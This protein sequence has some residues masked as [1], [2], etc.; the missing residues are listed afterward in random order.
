MADTVTGEDADQPEKRGR[1]FRISAKQKKAFLAFLA[2]TCHVRA[3]AAHAQIGLGSIYPLR[4]KDAAF[5][6]DWAEALHAGYQMLE[7]QLVGH[8]LSGGGPTLD[9]G[10]VELTGPIDV[11]L[12]M[13]LLTL[14]DSR[15]TARLRGGDRPVK[16][17]TAEQTDASILRKLASMSRAGGRA[18]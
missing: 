14:H 2:A 1:G 6:A 10:D 16:R 17:V 7:T 3:A 13:R 15:T 12:A 4:V 5:R 18:R 9:N 11:E 8:A